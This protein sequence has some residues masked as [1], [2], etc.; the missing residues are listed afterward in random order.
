MDYSLFQKL[1]FSRIQIGLNYDIDTSGYYSP[2]S[3]MQLITKSW[4]GEMKHPI[5]HLCTDCPHKS[6]HSLKIVEILKRI[7]KSSTISLF[8]K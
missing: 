2:I 8:G 6:I 1:A 7:F 5:R 4:P 3:V